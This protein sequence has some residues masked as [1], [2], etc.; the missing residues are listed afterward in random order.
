MFS[1]LEAMSKR[2]VPAILAVMAY[3]AHIGTLTVIA[4]LAAEGITEIS[5]IYSIERGY[6]NIVAKLTALGADIQ[7]ITE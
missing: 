6:E 7:K 4:G 5:D 2:R 3:R 1:A